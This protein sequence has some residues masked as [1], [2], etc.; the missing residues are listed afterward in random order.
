MANNPDWLRIFSVCGANVNAHIRPLL[1]SL[2]QPQPD[3]GVGAGGDPVRL[4]DLAAEKA[5]VEVLV[6]QAPSFTL[7]SE[8]SGIQKFGDMPDECY[9][10]LDPIDGTTNLSRGLQFYCSSIAVSTEPKLSSV[11]AASVTDLTHDVSYTALKGKGAERNGK[12]IKPSTLKSLGQAVIGVDLN[13]LEI[14]TV[15]AQL[16]DLIEVTPH[17]RHFGANALETCYVADGL[18][19]AFLDIRGKIR[20]TDVAAAFLVVEE[21]GGVVTDPEGEAIDLK[22]DPK[23]KLKFVASGNEEIH[24]A[25]LKLISHRR[26]ERH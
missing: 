4:V 1:G 18:T 14:K 24:Q 7:I 9:V 13:T 3:L 20:T 19:D 17:V 11:F 5:I 21:A 25:I 6:E 8:E 16:S 23:Q 12:K 22:L 2:K 15:A 26:K 10:T